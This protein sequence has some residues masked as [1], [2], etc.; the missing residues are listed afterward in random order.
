MEYD[1]ERN[2]IWQQVE[3]NSEELSERA[4]VEIRFG[5]RSDYKEN[6]NTIKILEIATKWFKKNLYSEKKITK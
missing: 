5:S 3:W 2:Q 6:D 4:G 1:F